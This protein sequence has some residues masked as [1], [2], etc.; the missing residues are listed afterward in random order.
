MLVLVVELGQFVNLVEV[1]L[2]ELHDG[3][4]ADCAVDDAEVSCK[5]EDDGGGD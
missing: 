5:V 2:F 1:L 3:E 4:D